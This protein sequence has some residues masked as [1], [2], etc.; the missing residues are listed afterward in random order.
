[1]VIFKTIIYFA[2]SI[3]N[4]VWISILN[5]NKQLWIVFLLL[6]KIEEQILLD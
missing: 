1:M 3:V 5:L 6:M 4:L 2:L